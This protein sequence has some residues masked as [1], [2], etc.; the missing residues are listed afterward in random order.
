LEKIRRR[1]VG[2]LGSPVKLISPQ[3]VLEI[4][5]LL[6]QEK[7]KRE[8]GQAKKAPNYIED[9]KRQLRKYNVYSGFDH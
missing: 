6:V 3:L 1:K 4:W 8:I 5:K 2:V 9:E 7:R